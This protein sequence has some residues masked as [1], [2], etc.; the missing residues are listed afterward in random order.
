MKMLI[1]ILTLTATA[2]AQSP[3]ILD[4]GFS[5]SGNQRISD[6]ILVDTDGDG[7]QELCAKIY[8][9]GIPELVLF[10]LKTHEEIARTLHTVQSFEFFAGDLEGD[11]KEEIILI[12]SRAYIG[13]SPT[14]EIFH[15]NGN[16]LTGSQF[17][18]PGGI[19]SRVGDV[20]GDGS[21]ELILGYLPL[22]YTDPGGIG[23]VNL[24]VWSWSGVD[25]ELLSQTPFHQ[26]YF[27][28]HVGDLDNDDRAEITVFQTGPRGEQLEE[29]PPHLFIHTKTIL[30]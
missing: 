29:K 7:E 27:Q 16:S 3:P 21:D 17:N 19:T 11:G 26:T 13:G 24:Q 2:W 9:S 8:G 4:T 22:G 6:A 5:V 1:T 12:D 28:L 14:I 15:R 23:P 10:D 30:I 25:F 18:T 20:D